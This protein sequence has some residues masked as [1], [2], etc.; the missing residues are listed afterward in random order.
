MLGWCR[1]LAAQELQAEEGAVRAHDEKLIVVIGVQPNPKKRRMNTS[2]LKSVMRNALTKAG[3]PE[4]KYPPGPDTFTC[5][6]E[7][8]IEPISSVFFSEFQKLLDRA[9]GKT[10]ES[11]DGVGKGVIV[12][13]LNEIPGTD[14]RHIFRL[15]LQDPGKYLHKL[16]VTYE[17]QTE[18]EFQPSDSDE[19][20][21]TQ[22]G[23][24]TKNRTQYWVRLRDYP[25]K[26]KITAK[27]VSKPDSEYEGEWPQTRLHFAVTF[28]NPKGDYGILEKILLDKTHDPTPEPIEQILELANTQFRLATIGW[29][30]RERS[31][32]RL[33]PDNLITVTRTAPIGVDVVWVKLPY[34]DADLTKE[35]QTWN[36][37]EDGDSVIKK[38]RTEPM[39]M[40]TG[41]EPTELSEST[42]PKWYRLERNE[43]DGVFSR[44][45]RLTDQPAFA[46]KY[47]GLSYGF[48]HQTDEGD[49]A[50]ASTI[51]AVWVD[52]VT[53]TKQDDADLGLPEL[54]E[55]PA[56]VD[57]RETSAPGTLPPE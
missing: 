45:F 48:I 12:S 52:K 16:K 5:D 11:Q 20:P 51:D 15:T 32:S 50:V 36:A 30:I 56:T 17:N 43:D 22:A 9:E 57:K 14:F 13:P 53:L 24:D 41:E 31:G 34:T 2:F 44:V 47:A 18:E 46:K 38:L 23:V 8:G 39:D 7:P 37:I 3:D 28:K 29:K 40:S 4:R 6:G 10:G 27:E 55:T 33:I 26:Y 54:D 25:V 21:V 42:P 35:L 1:N 49:K 19:E